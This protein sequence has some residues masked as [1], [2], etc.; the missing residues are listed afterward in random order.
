MIAPYKGKFKV[1]QCYKSQIHKGLDLVGLDSKIIHS[2]IS[3]I[4]EAAHW[5][6]AYD[7]K[8]GMGQYV[9]IRDDVTGYRFY[10]AHLSQISVKAGQRV[11][12]G[13]II[14][15]EGSTGHS[16][17]SH[18]HY[19]VRRVP[20]NQT[21]L[22]V[23]EISGIPNKLGICTIEEKEGADMTEAE[24]RKIVQEELNKTTTEPSSWAATF[25]KWGKEN[26]IT[27]GSNPQGPCTREQLVTMLKK[28]HD[29]I[30]SR[31]RSC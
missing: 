12:R 18:L 7:H 26:D 14:G 2:T 28:L 23:S 27:D 20:D 10:F 19:E 16:T 6:H 15:V 4:V 24:I 21:F 11:A 1:S 13:Q 29:L 17:G 8:Y 22:N 3:G 30:M 25:W 9:R 5:D 31:P